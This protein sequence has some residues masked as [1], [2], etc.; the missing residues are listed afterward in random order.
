[1]NDPRDI[2]DKGAMTTMQFVIVA[3][4]VLLNA[5]DGFDVLAISVSGPGIMS[6]WGIDRAQL[7]VILSMELIGMAFGSILL[8]GVADKYGRRSMTLGCLM[9]MAFGMYMATTA[10]S[11]TTLSLWRVFTGLGI[12]GML[13]T[14]NAVVAEF[15]NNRRRAMCISM[16]VIGYPIGGIFCGEIGKAMLD[17]T[18]SNWRTMFISGAV[19]SAALIPVVYFLVPE[20]IHWLARKQ[21]AGAL[22][23]INAALTKLGHAAV[24]A[25]P[26]IPADL[27]KKSVLDIFSPSLAMITILVTCAYFF[28]IITFYYILKWTPTLVVQMGMNASAAS[29]V[30]TWANVGGALGGA[31][32]GLLTTRFGLKPLS[33]AILLLAAVGVTLFGR[34]E[35]NITSL[36]YWAAF[37][38]F[39][40]NAGVS[41]LY[42]IVAYA[43]P[44]HVRATGT[45]FV[46]G[47]GRGGAV[48]S[49]MIAGYLLQSGTTLANVGMVMAI[50]SLL[51]AGVLFFLKMGTD[52]TADAAV[53][54][55][56]TSPSMKASMA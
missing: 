7:G 54:D 6:E 50:G 10:T 44:T 48:L 52:K 31:A 27:R 2:I 41:G 12:G 51:A 18:G 55:T 36:S 39:F 15:S 22:E 29:G 47:V 25:L 9:V 32:F 4:T 1:M 20:S 56:K 30:L 17:A 19:M 16:M 23:K 28:H 38:G 21:P 46:I 8:G 26:A 33:I 40:G 5:M 13:S 45:G 34:S 43:F 42:S 35:P 11:P 53:T 49:P 37:A 14:T 3:I 24:N